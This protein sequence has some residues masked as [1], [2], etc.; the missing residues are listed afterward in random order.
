MLRMDELDQSL[1]EDLQY[2]LSKS[3][4]LI[5]MMLQVAMQIMIM[6]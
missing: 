4:Y 5:D 6:F 2:I 1:Q 3:T